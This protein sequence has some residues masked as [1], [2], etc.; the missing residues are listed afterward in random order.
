MG[1]QGN[2][3]VKS[4]RG[5][6]AKEQGGFEPR[7]GQMNILVAFNDNY[8]MPTEVMLRSL[9]E[10]NEVELNIYALFAEL[11]EES[12]KSVKYLEGMRR[13]VR[14]IFIRVDKKLFAHF[15]LTKWWTMETYYRLFASDYLENDIDRILWLDSD[16]IVNRTLKDFYEQDFEGKLMIADEDCWFGS[17]QEIH[18]RLHMPQHVKYVNAGVILMDIR[19]LRERIPKELILSYVEKNGSNLLYNDQDIINGLL[20]PYVKVADAAHAYNFFSREITRQNKKH[21][22]REACIIHYSGEYKPWNKGYVYYGFFLW[23]RHALKGNRGYWRRFFAVLPS[24]VY[25]MIRH[26]IAVLIK[27]NKRSI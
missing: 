13:Q 12:R 4:K 7:G 10:S 25:S 17:N 21:V 26:R 2:I 15:P 11:S 9:I 23:W 8:V 20:Y 27:G 22:F 19:G 18:E 5:Q 16:I 6:V 14:V 24:S 3:S 1:S